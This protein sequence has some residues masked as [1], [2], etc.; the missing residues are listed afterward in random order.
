VSFM[1][2]ARS[3]PATAQSPIAFIEAKILSGEWPP[4]SRLPSERLLAEQFEVSRPVIREVLK[5]LQAQR[6]ID[7]FPGKGSYVTNLT[8]TGGEVSIEH[9]LRKGEITTRDLV[10]ARRMLE[11]EAAALAAVHR[12]DADIERLRAILDAFDRADKVQVAIDLDVAF[13]EAAVVASGNAVIQ[14]MFGSIRDLVRGM[15]LRSLTDRRVRRLGA[16]V[17]HTILDAIERGDPEGAR[18][19][20]AEHI[21][22][23][24]QM[25]GDDMDQPLADVLNRRAISDPEHAALLKGA[26]ARLTDDWR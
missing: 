20:V 16:P 7:V 26:S 9:L 12:T 10:T 18:E 1:A 15:V 13:H 24:E 8:P 19:A 6:L 4:G 17:H 22:L 2:G 25:Y 14:I 23:S 3:L 21:S 11:S 5:M